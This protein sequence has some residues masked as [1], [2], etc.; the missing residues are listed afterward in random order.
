ML[1]PPAS[2]SIAV[3][4][5]EDMRERSKAPTTEKD[6]SR[7]RIK[8][9]SPTPNTRGPSTPASLSVD[10]P[11][12]NLNRDTKIFFSILAPEIIIPRTFFAIKFNN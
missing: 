11:I 1:Y 12:L 8:R 5:P 9:P 6:H 7:I 4:K 10:I 2:A 3:D